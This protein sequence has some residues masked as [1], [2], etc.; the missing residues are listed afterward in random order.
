MR[1]LWKARRVTNT[2]SAKKVIPPKRSL[3]FVFV[4]G[5]GGCAICV[6]VDG[7]GVA[8]SSGVGFS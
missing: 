5:D 4:W 8:G 7:T 6:C 3:R 2:D 1:F